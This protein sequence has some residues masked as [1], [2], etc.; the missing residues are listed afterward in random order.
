MSRSAEGA[1]FSEFHTL[2]IYHFPYAILII[3]KVYCVPLDSIE[4][5]LTDF[6]D[7]ESNQFHETT[8]KIKSTLQTASYPAYFAYFVTLTV[9]INF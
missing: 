2:L 1:G 9:L 4:L 7:I 5:T 8:K 6:N 3:K